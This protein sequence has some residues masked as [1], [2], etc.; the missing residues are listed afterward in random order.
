MISASS[1][2]CTVFVFLS[3]N[4][5]LCSGFFRGTKLNERSTAIYYAPQPSRIRTGPVLTVLHPETG[6]T[7]HLVGVSHGSEAS[8]TL[9]KE[10]IMQKKPSAVVLELCE[11]RFLT[12]SSYAGIRPTDNATLIEKY[13]ALQ[14]ELQSKIKTHSN[15]NPFQKLLALMR[16]AKDQGFVSGVFVMFGIIVGTMQ[17]L[18]SSTNDDEF[19]SAIKVANDLNIPVRLGD[20][21]QNDTLNNIKN[22]I[23][24]DTLNPS[25]IAS[26]SKSLFF[27]ALGLCADSSNPLL[28]DLQKPPPSVL[29]SSDWLN[30]P[31][32]YSQNSKLSRSLKPFVA[33][34]AILFA[35]EQ[36]PFFTEH[37]DAA[38][39]TFSVPTLG[40]SDVLANTVSSL[41]PWL[42][43][44]SIATSESAIPAAS[45]SASISI[46]LTETI[47]YIQR[48]VDVLSLLMLIRM[49]KI[50]GTD[51]DA[52]IADKV[53]DA[54][55]EFPGKE[56]VVVIG[57]LHCNGV[58]RWL[59]SGVPSLPTTA[60][61]D[62]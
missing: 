60:T 61:S 20:A 8:S 11:D 23:S 56:V 26:G 48:V 58:A 18:I 52:I 15:K 24:Y 10:V 19:T 54:C 28:R 51:R 53:N 21:P 17:K 38:V 44:P 35:V 7:V 13:D 50:I 29:A 47:E 30:I 37:A 27:S 1:T 41:L 25:L 34:A 32:A 2:L 55:R 46:N 12:I 49:T 43:I 36:L 16:F 5:L 39:D 40:F 42:A 59:M 22:I 4:S 45:A 9:V 57:M 31:L 14:P 6:T 3:I 62:A 33:L